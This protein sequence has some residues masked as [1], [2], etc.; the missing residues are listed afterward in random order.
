M[1]GSSTVDHGN[2]G[3]WGNEIYQES[4]S[5]REFEAYGDCFSVLTQNGDKICA[6]AKF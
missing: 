2:G 4:A 1:R 6:S 5:M 3:K